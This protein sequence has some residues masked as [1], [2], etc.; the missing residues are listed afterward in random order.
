MIRPNKNKLK[1]I[2]KSGDFE[3]FQGITRGSQIKS[4]DQ[5]AEISGGHIPAFFKYNEKQKF[6]NLQKY[7]NRKIENS[8]YTDKIIKDIARLQDKKQ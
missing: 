4:E 7:V 8:R 3:L 6:R 5:A 1:F 2:C